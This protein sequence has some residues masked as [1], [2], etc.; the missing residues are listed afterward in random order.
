[1]GLCIGPNG[2][3]SRAKYPL[4]HRR[5]EMIA[6]PGKF[7]SVYLAMRLVRGTSFSAVEVPFDENH[8][9]GGARRLRRPAD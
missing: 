3:A 1:M 4:K 6:V 5:D 8:P 9:R 7:T 2:Y